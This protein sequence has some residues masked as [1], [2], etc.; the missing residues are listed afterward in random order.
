MIIS[1]FN[2]LLLNSF[3]GERDLG[4]YSAYFLS[5]TVFVMFIVKVFSVVFFPTIA[6]VDKEEHLRSIVKKIDQFESYSMIP[7]FLVNLLAIYVFMKFYGAKYD[8]NWWYLVLIAF[9]STFSLFT[10]IRQYFLA[11]VGEKGIKISLKIVIIVAILSI[12]YYIGL[13][14]WFHL[15]GSFISLLLVSITFYFLNRFFIKKEYAYDK[16]NSQ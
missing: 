4:V 14:Y 6:K 16:Q 3:L 5:S 10:Y 2:R 8:F 13:V 12:A 9:S 7:I 1:S 11:A 15:L